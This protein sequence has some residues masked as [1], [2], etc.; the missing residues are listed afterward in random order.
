MEIIWDI[1]AFYFNTSARTYKLECIE[2]V[3]DG[4]SAEDYDEIFFCS[5]TR[6][7]ERQEFRENDPNYWYKVLSKNCKVLSI[8]SINVIHKFPDDK[9]IDPN[10][11]DNSR[12]GLN[13]Y[14]LGLIIE[15]DQG[16]V[17]AFLLPSNHDFH[18]FDKIHFHSL[19]EINQLLSDNIEFYEIINCA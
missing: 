3:P 13:K 16:F 19:M 14:S 10:K 7:K 6:L 4:G 9:L 15:T 8:K 12:A 11:I 18:W 1:N 2:E 17:P 5:V